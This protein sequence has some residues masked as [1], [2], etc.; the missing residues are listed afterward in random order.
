MPTGGQKILSNPFFALLRKDLTGRQVVSDSA[1]D[2]SDLSGW[3][4]YNRHCWQEH[5][6]YEWGNCEPPPQSNFSDD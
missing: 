6:S 1:V 3:N 5:Q 2:N 4:T